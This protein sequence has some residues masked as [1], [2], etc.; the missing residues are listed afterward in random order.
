[1]SQLHLGGEVVSIPHTMAARKK[2]SART[3]F[4]HLLKRISRGF[5]SVAPMVLPILPNRR[6]AGQV[7]IGTRTVSYYKHWPDDAK[8]IAHWDA[9]CLATPGTTVYQSP[10]W[11]RGATITA[12]AVGRL[13]LVTVH[14]GDRLV[15]VAPFERHFGGEWTTAAPMSSQYHDPLIAADDPQ[16]T[17]DAL[18]RG[19]AE[20]DP[21]LQSLTFELISSYAP[22][23]DYVPTLA[24]AAGYAGGEVPYVITDTVIVLAETWDAYLATLS[25]NQRSKLRR[26]LKHVEESG[27]AKLVVNT[28]EADVVKALPGVLDLMHKS[29]GS[30]GRKT[31][32]LYRRHL[33]HTAPLLAKDGR[34]VIYQLFIDDKLAASDVLLKQGD[35]Y[36]FWN[37]AIA[38]EFRD[39]SPGIA[40][41][42]MMMRHAIEQGVKVVDLLQGMSVC[43]HEMGAI[44]RPQHKLV[45]TR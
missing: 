4:K 35:S 22:F 20:L 19:I 31:N 45:F 30:K 2:Y 18:L 21:N 27:R 7:K 43:K 15:A 34:M 38:D 23:V 12:D 16:A 17:W 26:R 8:L 24:K 37:G 25:K 6:V 13:R 29:G 11:Q 36:I 39:L 1:M 5:D 44:E 41:Q 14:D 10:H 28:T 40:M 9:L 42:A 33:A 32:W 3:Q